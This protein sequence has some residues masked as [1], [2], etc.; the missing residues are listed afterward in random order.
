VGKGT[1]ATSDADGAMAGHIAPRTSPLVKKI[2]EKNQGERRKKGYEC[3]LRPSR[4][5]GAVLNSQFV[6]ARKTTVLLPGQTRG[7]DHG[8][9]QI[10]KE[11]IAGKEKKQRS[12]LAVLA[13]RSGR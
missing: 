11:R 9:R 13:A 8:A 5:T 10:K 1:G 6:N 2:S 3:T 4:R 7:G 12:R